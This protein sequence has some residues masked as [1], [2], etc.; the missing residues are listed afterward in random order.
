MDRCHWSSGGMTAV[1]FV[2]SVKTTTC[3]KQRRTTSA[4]DGTRGTRDL[5]LGI[6]E[7]TKN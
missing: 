3:C 1:C 2:V 6:D 7:R 5:P 4:V